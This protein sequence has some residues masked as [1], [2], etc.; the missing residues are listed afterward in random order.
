[1]MLAPQLPVVYRF[2]QDYFSQ[3]INTHQRTVEM[4]MSCTIIEILNEMIFLG[5]SGFGK[6]GN[7]RHKT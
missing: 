3:C 2:L 7:I 4:Q 1:M 6:F 5:Q